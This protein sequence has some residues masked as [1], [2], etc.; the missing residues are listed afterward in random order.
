ML[1]KDKF[2][3]A[4]IQFVAKLK[5]DK[6]IV[7]AIIYGS[8]VNGTLWEKSDIDMILIVN[9]EKLPYDFR[10]FIEQ[11]IIINSLV[12]SRQNFKRRIQ[13][14]IQGDEFHSL[15]HQSKLLYTTD[16]SIETYYEGITDIGQSDKA[17][18]LLI[19]GINAVA[20]YSKAMKGL[21]V[22][23]DATYCY[24]KMSELIDNLAH[25]TVL[26]NNQIPLQKVVLQAKELDPELMDELYIRYVQTVPDEK[27]VACLMETIHRFLV[28]HSLFLF[29]PILQ[30]ITESGMAQPVS[31]LHEHLFKRTQLDLPHF[32]EACEWLADL[33][34]VKRVPSSVRLTSRSRMEVDE[35]AY[36]LVHGGKG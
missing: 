19:Y 32:L 36:Y 18:Q 12:F 11:G 6:T 2:D 29:E 4:L 25:L 8:Y 33:N 31:Y 5:E 9:D 16:P 35:P 27:Q 28:R 22:L 24:Y 13:G 14:I 20:G 1:L 26:M 3:A 17:L 15:F 23:G 34:I 21:K 30:L 7:A 10:S